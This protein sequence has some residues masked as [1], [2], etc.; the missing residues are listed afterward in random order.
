MLAVARLIAF[1]PSRDLERSKTFYVEVLSG[2]PPAAPGS[3]GSRIPTAT[4]Y[5]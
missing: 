5:S 2:T 4:C 3:R 1:V